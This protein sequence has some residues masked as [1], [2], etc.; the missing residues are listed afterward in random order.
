MTRFDVFMVTFTLALGAVA[1]VAMFTE[2]VWP[3]D[4]VDLAAVKRLK[5]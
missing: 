4:Y 5:R 2:K 1:L 3:S